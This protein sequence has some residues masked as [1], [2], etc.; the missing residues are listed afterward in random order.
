[1]NSFRRIEKSLPGM[2][3]LS[4]VHYLLVCGRFSGIPLLMR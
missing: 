3:L 2:P 4:M 1:L